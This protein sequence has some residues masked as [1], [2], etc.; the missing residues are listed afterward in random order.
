MNFDEMTADELNEY[1]AEQG[2]NWAEIT[3]TD[4]YSVDPATDVEIEMVRDYL[5]THHS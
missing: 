3:E 2:V 4:P 5:R 1:L